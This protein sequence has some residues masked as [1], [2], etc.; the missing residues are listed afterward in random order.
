VP[1]PMDLPI[2]NHGKGIMD[3]NDP[4]GRDQ[5]EDQ[6]FL[7]DVD[8]LIHELPDSSD[9]YKD[10]RFDEGEIGFKDLKLLDQYISGLA[11]NLKIDDVNDNFITTSNEILSRYS[12]ENLDEF[13]SPY[14]KHSKKEKVVKNTS[15]KDNLMKLKKIY[16]SK[17]I[18]FCKYPGYNS[19]SVTP[20]PNNV[21][22][23]DIIDKVLLTFKP[24]YQRRWK[25]YL[26]FKESIDIICDVFW[27]SF[28]LWYKKNFKDS[29]D[30][31]YS[32]LSSNYVK[33][34]GKLN[35]IDK[36]EFLVSYS[37]ILSQINFL[38]YC[39]CFPNSK[40]TFETNDFKKKDCDL[41]YGWFVGSE[42]FEEVWINWR[43]INSKYIKLNR[44]MNKKDNSPNEYDIIYN[45]DN[46]LDKSVVNDID[47]VFKK[48]RKKTSISQPSSLYTTELKIK[49]LHKNINNNSPI[50]SHYIK[51]N[52]HDSSKLPYFIQSYEVTRVP[53]DPNKG[54]Y[55]QVIEDSVK[56]T[57]KNLKN[58][59]KNKEEIIKEKNR[60]N[61]ETIFYMR[62]FNKMTQKLLTRPQQVKELC[63]ILCEGL[64][65]NKITNGKKQLPKI[66][67]GKNNKINLDNL[68][69]SLFK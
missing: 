32:R 8:E 23:T 52:G 10:I 12:N 46:E 27:L 29:F 26:Y 1:D 48:N 24:N 34:I 40:S 6:H 19:T 33:F 63:D 66:N 54:S 2:I 21:T 30:L 45:M 56:R 5:C 3:I 36:N 50:I 25:V 47:S 17:N 69:E 39:E 58:Y 37:L 55:Q 22:P 68:D 67:S 9:I 53:K 7:N 31:T 64:Y 20:L 44:S 59:L 11:K 4:N 61:Q 41:I 16:E 49:K 38:I 14:K 51:N 43:S 60:G 28:I 62:K 57:N 65:S 15:S 42:P 13:K 18:E 35:D